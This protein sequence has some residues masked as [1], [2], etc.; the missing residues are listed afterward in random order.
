MTEICYIDDIL[1]QKDTVLTVGT[2]D[3]IHQGHLSLMTRLVQKAKE[4]K[5]RSV[6]VSFDPHPRSI[7]H[8]G[9]EGIKLLTTL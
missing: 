6:V 2:F 4:P 5:C 3:G 9:D 1:Y 7:N 8:A